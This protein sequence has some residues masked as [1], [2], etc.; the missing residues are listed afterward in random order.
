LHAR[1]CESEGF[2]WLIADDQQA[3]VFAW[4]RK[5][6]GEP[7]IAVICNMTPALHDHYRL[8]LP[9]NGV[10]REVF[11]SDAQVYGGSG[12]GNLGAITVQN[13]AAHVILPPL[14]TL[15]FEYGG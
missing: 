13:G 11:N 10:W 7:C 8:P 14:A 1:D 6:P 15:M 12:Q 5:A 2:E 4:L 9:H 3:S